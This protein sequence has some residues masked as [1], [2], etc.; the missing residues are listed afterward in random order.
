MIFLLRVVI[1]WRKRVLSKEEPVSFFNPQDSLHAIVFLVSCAFEG[2][3]TLGGLELE[4]VDMLLRDLDQTW[5]VSESQRDVPGSF[6]RAIDDVNFAKVVYVFVDEAV[7]DN[8]ASCSCLCLV[9]ISVM[10]CRTSGPA[11]TRACIVI[12]TKGT[13]AS[14]QTAT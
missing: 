14:L 10:G 11:N 2:S 9:S 5:F 1:R 6:D 13:S 4:L 7:S 12:V 8:F 3:F